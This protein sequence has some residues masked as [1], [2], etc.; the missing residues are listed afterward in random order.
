MA[1]SLRRTIRLAL[2]AALATC[3]VGPH[4]APAVAAPSSDQPAA[5]RARVGRAVQRLETA[6]AK[7]ARAHASVE[8]ASA[9]LDRIVADQQRARARLRARVRT[10][11]R[12]GD[13]PVISTLLSAS[14]FQGLAARMDLLQ[15]M[16]RQDAEDLR[17][18]AIARA[19]VERAAA[20]SMEL[21]AAEARAFDATA[22]E[23]A[24]ARTELAASQSALRDYETRAAAG[25]KKPVAPKR[26]D[27]MQRLRGSGEW[28]TA[29][30]SHYGRSFT[31]RGASGETIGPYSMIVAHRTLPF[32]TL[33]EFEYRGKRA[34][35]RVADRGP[36][37]PGRVFDLGPGV[38]RT[39][40]F[41]GVNEVLYRIIAR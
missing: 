25:A 38:V 28:K 12:S 10:M 17:T 9:E 15:R 35:A 24:R 4:L 5:D 6:C 30:A 19:E 11:Y 22:R 7:S 40:D 1:V 13:A 29:V 27:P 2:A 32:G 8:R 18:L 31:G 3:L 36:H 14:T 26:S 33:I 16:S 23:V 39:L 41:A 21:Q 37:T 20:R 34:V